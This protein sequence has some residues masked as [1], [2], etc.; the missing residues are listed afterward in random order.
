MATSTGPPMSHRLFRHSIL[1]NAR[2]RDFL[3]QVDAAKAEAYR[4]AGC[5]RCGGAL[6]SATYPRK[7]HGL[8][9]SLRE[10]IRRFSLCCSV[11]RRRVQPPSCLS[12]MPARA[13]PPAPNRRQDAAGH[14]PRRTRRARTRRRKPH[15]RRGPLPGTV[16]ASNAQAGRVTTAA[17]RQG[18]TALGLVR[19]SARA[20]AGKKPSE[21]SPAAPSPGHIALIKAT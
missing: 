10:E 17:A 18:L 6:H 19:A 21:R 8:A 11:C 3:T 7:P 1:S 15:H 14:G 4:A 12:A 2:V 5:P 13:P 9:A 16:T 20:L